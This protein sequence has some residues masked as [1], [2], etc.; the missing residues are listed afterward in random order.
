MGIELDKDNL[1]DAKPVLK[2]KRPS[3]YTVTLN[4]QVTQNAV[5][6]NIRICGAYEEVLRASFKKSSTDA[7]GHVIECR[8]EHVSVISTFP[9]EVAQTKAKQANDFVKKHL[10]HGFNPAMIFD[11]K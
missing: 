5:R 3:L 7:S 8:Q 10:P 6:Q 2:Q 1:L 4:W 11:I 9:W